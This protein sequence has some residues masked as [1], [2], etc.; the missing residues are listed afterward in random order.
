MSL[1]AWFNIYIQSQFIAMGF[2]SNCRFCVVILDGISSFTII[3]KRKR[4]NESWLLYYNCV[5][6]VA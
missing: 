5:L 4:E 2:F 1:H 6:A 3:L